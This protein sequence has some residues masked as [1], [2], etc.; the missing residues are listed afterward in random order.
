MKEV[1]TSFLKEI[2]KQRIQIETD[3]ALIDRGLEEKECFTP[4]V[5]V[6]RLLC[7][8]IFLVRYMKALEEL[9]KDIELKERG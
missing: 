8:R 2:A 9:V 7:V 5:D 6:T 3:I 1:Y 4:I